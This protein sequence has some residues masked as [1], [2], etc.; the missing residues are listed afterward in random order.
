MN[1]TTIAFIEMVGILA[2]LSFLIQ[3]GFFY[4]G[5]G[6]VVVMWVAVLYSQEVL[7]SSLGLL[8]G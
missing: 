4:V 7:G 2:E 1:L 8:T 6:I 5:C 3:F